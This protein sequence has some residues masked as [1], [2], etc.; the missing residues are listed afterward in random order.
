M[1]LETV[2]IKWMPITSALPPKDVDV[3]IT[4]EEKITIGSWYIT[5]D[6]N[7]AWKSYEPHIWN[8]N[9]WMP[10]PEMTPLKF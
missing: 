9:Q 7:I 6:G 1:I 10:L 3:I 5:H 2:V 8:P 4:D